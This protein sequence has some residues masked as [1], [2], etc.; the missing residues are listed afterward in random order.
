MSRSPT[1]PLKAIA[2]GYE[3]K[4]ELAAG[5]YVLSTMAGTA[6]ADFA[7][8]IRGQVMPK[9][10]PPEVIDWIADATLVTKFTSTLVKPASEILR[11]FK[12]RGGRHV[13]AV[14]PE[15]SII[16]M[17]AASVSMASNLL[18]GTKIVV[19]ATMKDA[20]RMLNELKLGGGA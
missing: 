11:D 3:V 7:A 6:D 5:G 2:A 8:S 19:V 9:L 18:G 10:K 4:T 17:A 12:A 13:V 15:G 14:I 16:R 1:G 20:V